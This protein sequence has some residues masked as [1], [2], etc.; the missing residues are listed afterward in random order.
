MH[1][2]RVILSTVFVLLCF[3][4]LPA[5]A[6]D[7][8]RD[9]DQDRI[10]LQDQTGDQV[11][12]RDLDRDQLRVSR[13]DVYGWDIMS[14]QE[15]REYAASMNSFGTETEREQFRVEHRARMQERAQKLGVVLPGGPAPQRHEEAIQLRPTPPPMHQPSVTPGGGAGGRGR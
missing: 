13:D 10:Q 1:A 4:A 3:A 6:A 8:A 7:Q 2:T 5:V 12:D 9:R 14:E 11:P 15:R